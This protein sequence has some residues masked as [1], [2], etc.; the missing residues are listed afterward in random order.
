[1]SKDS[2]SSLPNTLSNPHPEII[3]QAPEILKVNASPNLCQ[4]L[5]R[6]LINSVAACILIILIVNRLGENREH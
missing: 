1:M 4:M 5:I 2:D 3:F 6:P